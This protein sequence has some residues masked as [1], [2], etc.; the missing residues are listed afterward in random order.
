LKPGDPT[1]DEIMRWY[2]QTTEGLIN[3]RNRQAREA[4]EPKE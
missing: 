2:S 1:L 3:E 4:P